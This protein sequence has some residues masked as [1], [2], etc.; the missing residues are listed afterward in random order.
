[1]TQLSKPIVFFGTEEFSLVALQG[2]IDAGFFI[3][4]VV[5]KPD[6]KKGRGHKI[7]PPAVKTLAIKHNIPVWQPTN[8]RDITESVIALGQPIGVLVSY[9]KIIPQSIIDLFTPGIVN[10]HPSL[11]PA[12]RGPSPIESAILNGDT[13]TGVSIMHLSARMDAGPV[14]AQQTVPLV[15]TETATDLYSKL[16]SVG[17]D[18]LVNLLPGITDGTNLPTPQNENDASYCKLIQKSDGIIDWHTMSATQI[19]RMVRAYAAW[20]QCRGRIKTT[21]VIIT[22]VDVIITSNTKLAPGEL[23]VTKT[24]LSVATHSGTLAINSVKP[25]GKKEMPIAAFLRGYHIQ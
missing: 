13:Q 7:V 3:A 22:S 17:T 18:M 16:G 12:Y 25:I 21:D 19:E 4:A 14:Y 15:G 20:P 23:I 6:T 11:L 8:L 2:L 9:G 24:S 5:T 10:V 1:M